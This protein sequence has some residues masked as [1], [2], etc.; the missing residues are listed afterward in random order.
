MIHTIG[1]TSQIEMVKSRGLACHLNTGHFEPQTSFFQSGFQTIILIPNHL[2]T[3]TNLPFEYQTSPVFK[4]LLY[5][6]ASF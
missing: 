6:G 3:K 1:L 5:Y 2:T 4:W